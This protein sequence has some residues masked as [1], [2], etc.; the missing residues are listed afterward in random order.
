M[1]AHSNDDQRPADTH[2]KTPA[3]TSP[4]DAG[5]FCIPTATVDALIDG[6]ASAAEIACC[7]C[8][9]A[10]TDATG[11]FTAASTNAVQKR[12]GFNW[13]KIQNAIAALCEREVMGLPMLSTREQFVADTG[14]TPP[15]G[16]VERSK[17]KFVFGTFGQPVADRVWFGK[18]LIGGYKGFEQPLRRLVDAGDVAARLL[19]LLYRLHDMEEWIGV[20]PS[21]TLHVGFIPVKPTESVGGGYRL[22][23]FKQDGCFP[24]QALVNRVSNAGS[25]PHERRD[26]L[27]TALHSL[28][29]IGLVYEAIVVVNRAPMREES[30]E[31]GSYVYHLPTDAEPKHLLA[32]R[33]RHG[34]KTKGEGGIGGETARLAGEL[35]LPVSTFGGFFDG[36]YAAFSPPGLAFGITGVYRLRFRVANGR[37][38][39]VK[40]AWARMYEGEREALAHL[41]AVRRINRLGQTS[42]PVPT[43]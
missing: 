14:Q 9:A 1:E 29:A 31:P 43:P 39:F 35:R 13:T 20:P 8:L 23:R 28:I 40:D 17:V 5:S 3:G 7:L 25:K 36:T 27:Q 12:T 6:K 37:N 42:K 19:L 24:T 34:Y 21:T 22:I 33:N 4:E 41:Q 18:G 16:P 15:D 30:E 26:D 32:T 38:A 2:V 11:A 10:F